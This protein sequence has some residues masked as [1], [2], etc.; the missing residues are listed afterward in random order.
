MEDYVHEYYSVSRF[1]A[2]Y[3]GE[4]EPLTDKTQWPH[5]DTGFVLR[6]P[7]P[8]GKKKGAGRTRK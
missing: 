6:A 3:E 8:T 7:L 5:V 4:I 2:A 1:S